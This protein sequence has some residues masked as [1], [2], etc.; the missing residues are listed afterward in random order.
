MCVGIVKHKFLHIIRQ[1]KMN[2]RNKLRY[3]DG[4]VKPALQS[5]KRKLLVFLLLL[6]SLFTAAFSTG[7][8]QVMAED[9][10]HNNTFVDT[11]GHF[12]E[13]SIEIWSR[14]GIIRGSDSKFRPNSPITRGEFA[15]ILNRLLNFEYPS[16]TRDS[17]ID[18]EDRFYTNAVLSLNENGILLGSGAKIRA[19][20][21]VTR[22]E[23]AV[24]LLRAFQVS[25]PSK[26]NSFIDKEEI[27]P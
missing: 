23:A 19:E 27:S 2:Q 17:F 6:L 3:F 12:A 7:K 14:R 25:P 16:I 5:F 15:L 4:E 10:K 26:E 22:E 11:R 24:M 13:E 21:P 9:L 8:F 1:N 18:L 20:D